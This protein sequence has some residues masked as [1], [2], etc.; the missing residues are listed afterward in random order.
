M[1]K[2]RLLATAFALASALAIRAAAD[3]ARPAPAEEASKG[4]ARTEVVCKTERPTGSRIPREVCRTRAQI[5]D[6]AAAGK[7]LVN[8]RK[9]GS[10]G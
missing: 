4:A 5:E 1:K 2:G 3:P 6:S 8:R 7:W 10:R 9:H